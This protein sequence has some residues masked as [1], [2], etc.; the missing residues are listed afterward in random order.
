MDQTNFNSFVSS[1]RSY[2][3]SSNSNDLENIL[4]KN[5]ETDIDNDNDIIYK[6]KKV[7]GTKSIIKKNS[8]CIPNF[9]Q[10]NDDENYHESIN[11]N[12]NN[13]YETKNENIN[14]LEYEFSNKINDEN[15]HG[16]NNEY[17]S[18]SNLNK[19]FNSKFDIFSPKDN[20]YLIENPEYATFGNTLLENRSYNDNNSNDKEKIIKIQSV[21]RGSIIRKKVFGIIY[22]TIIY[23]NFFNKLSN[24]LSKNAR[25]FVLKI[26]SIYYKLKKIFIKYNIHNYYFQRWKCI[27]KLL[28]YKNKNKNNQIIFKKRKIY[29]KNNKYSLL[30]RFFNIWNQNMKR[31][32]IFIILKNNR[33]QFLS[34]N[35][36]INNINIY[37]VNQQDKKE[38]L[39]RSLFIYEYYQKDN[40]F[41]KRYYF[42]RWSNQVKNIELHELKKR[43]LIYIINSISKKSEIK[44]LKKYFERWKLS[45]VLIFSKKI[46]KN[47]VIKQQ[48][49][50]KKTNN[51]LEEN[52]LVFDN[53]GIEKYNISYNKND[54][55]ETN[56]EEPNYKLNK[57]QKK[58]KFE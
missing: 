16:L 4:I 10:V 26:I 33:K 1:N 5:M 2:Q 29:M 20:T 15:Y 49:I 14:D 47:K 53:K 58:K 24:I 8:N 11:N 18:E 6:K 35:N 41:I 34:N 54:E 7:K 32:D 3:N 37:D 28:I 45:R 31:Y 40:L 22:M 27:I 52:T 21:W 56:L 55:E 43:I 44:I 48:K 39:R 25:L 57:I 36:K 12:I 23:Q 46:A 30:K 17:T 50:N 13:I 38:I 19:K 9:A 42:F 51:T